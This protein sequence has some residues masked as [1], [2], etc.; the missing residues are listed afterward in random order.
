[1]R[2]AFIS[3]IHANLP[4]LE[5]IWKDIAQQ[6]PDS[7]YCLGDL[8]NFAGWDN[9][10]VDFIRSNKIASIQ[11]NH[12][13]GIGSGSHD[14]SFSFSSPEQ[15]LFGFASINKVNETIRN[16]NRDYLKS[17]PFMIQLGAILPTMNI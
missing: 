16:D 9:E 2:I 14:F 5:A 8:V 4:A 7:I 3:D 6:A 12:D 10:V 1:M 15:K 11:G 17:L 13:E